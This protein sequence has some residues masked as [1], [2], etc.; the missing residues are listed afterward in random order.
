MSLPISYFVSTNHIT[1]NAFGKYCMSPR[2]FVLLLL[3]H[4]PKFNQALKILYW[5]H[6]L[7]D[8]W[9]KHFLCQALHVYQKHSGCLLESRWLYKKTIDDNILIIF[10]VKQNDVLIF[11]RFCIAPVLISFF[12]FLESRCNVLRFSYW[13]AVL[14]VHE[15]YIAW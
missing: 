9:R 6:T 4:K 3:S 5:I 14:T 12:V 2:V 13:L 11:V 8:F 1:I 15:I 10:I 7:H